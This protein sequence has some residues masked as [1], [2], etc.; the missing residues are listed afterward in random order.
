MR[1]IFAYNSLGTSGKSKV[2]PY[3]RGKHA[4]CRIKVLWRERLS[5]EVPTETNHSP[6]QWWHKG[7]RQMAEHHGIYISYDSVFQSTQ[8]IWTHFFVLLL[9]ELNISVPLSQ[10][11]FQICLLRLPEE[12]QGPT[13]SFTA[14]N[15]LKWS[16]SSFLYTF[17]KHIRQSMH[18]MP[19]LNISIF[20][21]QCLWRKKVL[22]NIY[23]QVCLH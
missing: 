14:S 16:Q 18:I 3:R 17:F 15:K 23:S 2:G 1:L 22:K 7:Y 9:V 20:S 10:L 8:E 19:T 13:A 4:L 21:C 6:K 12:Q 5:V 11:G